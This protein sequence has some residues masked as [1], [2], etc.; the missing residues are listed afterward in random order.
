MTKEEAIQEVNKAFEPAFANYIITALTEGATASDECEDAVSRQA[1]AQ[2][3]L[4]EGI[5]YCE[6][7]ADTCEFEASKYDMTDAYES[8][9]A[10]Q[11]GE[12]AERHRQFAEWLKELKQLREQTRWIPISE[13]PP[14]NKQQ[15]L[16]SVRGIASTKNNRYMATYST[17]LYEVDEFIFWNKKNVPGFYDYDSEYG[18]YEYDDIVAWRPLP[19][20][21]QE[22]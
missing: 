11:E 14:K 8:H 18:Y 17:N 6:E 12:C 9:V 15:C 19:P 7:V 5:K 2:W 13:R 4:E 1:V 10:C 20:S 16:I 21:Y 22:K 3:T